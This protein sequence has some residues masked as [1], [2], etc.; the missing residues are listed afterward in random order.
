MAGIVREVNTTKDFVGHK[1]LVQTMQEFPDYARYLYTNDYVFLNPCQLAT[2]DV[3]RTVS[4]T[5]EQRARIVQF[6]GV[7]GQVD[8]RSFCDAVYIPA[9]ISAKLIGILQRFLEH[10]VFLEMGV[11]LVL[12]A[13]EST[14]EWMD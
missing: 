14:E 2:R 11:G 8:V 1:T 4:F 7:P 12:V 5:A 13:I 9:R 6:T 3:G 10:N